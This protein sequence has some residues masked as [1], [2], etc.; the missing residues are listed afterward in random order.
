[1][2]I[3]KFV[4]P[5]LSQFLI[6]SALS[7]QAAQLVWDTNTSSNGAQDGAGIWDT[8]STNWIATNGA[9][10]AWNNANP[11]SA[12]FG[13]GAVGGVVTLSEPITI[14]NLTFANSGYT[15]SGGPLTLAGQQTITMNAIATIDATITGGGFTKA[16]ASTLTLGGANTFTGNVTVSSGTLVITNG[17]SL[18]SSPLVTVGNGQRL[19]LSGGVTVTNTSTVVSINNQGTGDSLGALNSV[20]GSNSWAGPVVLTA[21]QTRIGADTGSTFVLT[22][23]ISSSG[24]NLYGAAFRNFDAASSLTILSGASTYS[25]NTYIV[26]GKVVLDGG[27]NRL[28]VIS[29]LVLGN[30]GGNGSPAILDLNGFNQ[31]LTGLSDL[32]SGAKM[33]TNSS[34]TPVTLTISSSKNFSA[35]N[36]TVIAGNLT[37]VNSGTGTQI[38]A[39]AASTFSGGTTINGGTLAIGTDGGGTENGNGL[40]IGLVTVNSGGQLRFG[41]S[42]AGTSYNITNNVQLAGG[43]IWSQDGQQ[44]LTNATFTVGAAGGSLITVSSNRYLYIDDALTGSGPLTV[45]NALT[46]TN[47]MGAVRF[48]GASNSYSGTITVNPASAGYLGGRVSIDANS[49]LANATLVMQ[50]TNDLGFGTSAT[51]PVLGALAGSGTITLPGTVT[52]AAGNNASNTTYSGVLTGGGTFTKIGASTLTLSGNNTMTN[53]VTI[54]GG[55][56][57]L[58]SSGSLSNALVS[59]G[60]AGTFDVTA[61]SPFI[62]PAGEPLLGNGTVSGTVVVADS[63]RLLPGG[64]G[65]P[66]TLT[67]AGSLAMN[68]NA[69]NTFDL[70]TNGVAGGGVNDLLIINGGLEPSGSVVRINALAALGNGTYPLITYTG[71]KTTSFNPTP[72]GNLTHKTWTIDEATSGQVNFVI[73]GTYGNLRWNPVSS[74]NWN[75]ADTNWFDVVTLQTNNFL[76]FDSVL[77]DDSGAFSPVVNLAATVQP[78]SFVVNSASNYTITGSGKITGATG[79]TKTGPGTLTLGGTDNDYSGL[80]TISNG[81]LKLV[82]ASSL[83]SR[84]AGTIINGGTLD[85]NGTT[86]NGSDIITI[87]GNGFAN[88]GTII[89]SGA[90]ADRALRAMVLGSDASIG[91]Y[92]NAWYFRG[93]NVVDLAGFTLTKLG[94]GQ[95]FFVEMTLTNVGTINVASGIM[96]IAR[97]VT[98][99]PG[100]IGVASN[101]MLSLENYSAGYF[102]KDVALTSGTFRALGNSLTTSS[103]VSVAGSSIIDV[104]AGIGFGLINPVTGSGS[105]TKTENG[106][107]VFKN[108]NSYPGATTIASGGGSI[109]LNAATGQTIF[110]PVQL[111]TVS[112]GGGPTIL[113]CSNNN[114]FAAGVSIGFGGSPVD[115]AQLKLCG[116]SQSV[117]S[118]VSDDNAGGMIDNAAT[119]NGVNSDGLLVIA[120]SGNSI[121]SGSNMRDSVSP[122]TS[123]GKLR[124]FQNG[125]GTLTLAGAGTNMTFAGGVT[126]NNGT[127]NLKAL[128]AAGLGTVTMAG[129][130]LALD[131]AGMQEG[132]IK[133]NVID[134]ISPNPLN[135]GVK[136]SD[137]RANMNA[138]LTNNTE[139][140]YSGYLVVTNPA[141]VTYTFAE[142]FDDNVNLRL[143]GTAVLNDLTGYNIPTIGTVALSPGMHRFDLR[144]FNGASGGGPVNTQWWT[145]TTIGVGFDPLG[146]GQTNMANYQAIADAGDGKLL[147]TDV[148]ISNNISLLAN[149]Q[150]KVSNAIGPTNT[151]AGAITDGGANLSVTKIGSGI[152]RFAG[153]NTYGGETTVSNGTLL[154]DGYNFGTGA[155]EVQT[156]A[157]LWGTGFVY[158]AA[159]TVDGGG[160]IGPRIGTASGGT[161]TVTNLT[162]N[163]GAVFSALLNGSTPTIH[164]MGDV[165]TAPGITLRLQPLA[166]MAVGTH[167]LLDYD[168]A[169]NGSA[170]DF[171]VASF[172]NGAQGYVTNNLVNTSIDLVITNAGAGLKWDGG[173]NGTWDVAGAVNWKSILSGTTQTFSPGD[174]VVFDDTAS[175]NFAINLL[176]SITVTSLSI[177]NETQNYSFSGGGIGGSIGITKYGAAKLSLL[178]ANTFTGATVVAAGTLAINSDSS[179]GTAPSAATP[180]QLTLN[181]G[182]TLEALTNVVVNANRRLAIGPSSGSG[183]ATLSIATGSTVTAS[184]IIANTPG[185]TGAFVK[186]GSGTLNL[187]LVNTYSGG[188]IFDGGT[189]QITTTTGGSSPIPGGTPLTVQN[190]ATLRLANNNGTCLGQNTTMP[191]VVT[192]S[193]ARVTT[194]GGTHQDLPTMV[195]NGGYLS[196]EAPGDQFGN[197]I[198]DK[199]NFITLASASTS[200]ID[201]VS[202]DLR[203][204][205][206]GGAIPINFNVADGAA[207]IDLLVSAQVMDLPG[208]TP[209][210]L[211]KVG[212]G[213]MALVT[214]PSTNI[215]SG[216]TL[217]NNGTFML[218]TNSVAAPPGRG[219]ITNNARLVFSLS[220]GV[221]SNFIAG[222]GVV[223]NAGTGTVTLTAN[224]TYSGGTQISNGTLV[225]NGA[226]LGSG[227][228][229]LSAGAS[230]NVTGTISGSVTSDGSVSPGPTSPTLL[231]VSQNYTQ[232][233]NGALNIKIGGTTGPG[234]D[235]D[236]L[237]VGSAAT[238][239][240]RL[241]VSVINGYSG[242]IGDSFVI[243]S[244]GSALTN[245]FASTNLASLGGGNVWSMTYDGAFVVLSVTSAPAASGYDAWAAGITN[246]KTAYNQFGTSDGYPNL[247]KYATGSSP[248]NSDALARMTSTQ[249]NGLF[250]LKFNHSTT[251]TDITIYVEGSYNIT[252]EA[253]SGI[254]TNLNGSWGAASNVSEDTNS[255]PAVDVVW[256]TD[257]TATN[258]FLRMRVTKP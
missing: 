126:V 44:H 125:S 194:V 90:S 27:G 163:S 91:S 39:K 153:G 51:A 107:L 249:T 226:A 69:T 16:N 247:L 102:D 179:L 229:T 3:R 255:V 182:T 202:I 220:A 104:A 119:D 48:T 171:T 223:V 10:V 245:G 68:A 141:G 234:V 134:L 111:G 218:G 63:A 30:G 52:L 117:D 122:S 7:L 152:L 1:M 2:N 100:V 241:N 71:S 258:R 116:T 187:P 35:T 254:A 38:L 139:W 120:G 133:T 21:D 25:G 15:I 222:T 29:A 209:G 137:K 77:F 233:A 36:G 57:A 236:K 129:G 19:R 250:A 115:W 67:I 86:N 212:A 208:G 34:P 8:V 65:T 231:T 201:A 76:N 128:N 157:S 148:T 221:I 232:T 50:S 240:G 83:G 40:G 160:T 169:F 12:T 43:T 54:S 246:G 95:M 197:Y 161:L 193:V 214:A 144:V 22:G 205:Y 174:A 123:T 33:I 5:V 92:G 59:V 195:L 227:A 188:T 121:F 41:G 243:L 224:N 230:L 94:G 238:L 164:A 170:G 37:L 150:I 61:F 26:L 183:S 253:W 96:S 257:A 9:N 130:V 158:M 186:V 203:G 53:F 190:G 49:A 199:T 105:L 13:S 207:D 176:Q 78:G 168:A 135:S 145:N 191:S 252:N 127:L 228:V 66:G 93:T 181:A 156:N 118:I 211:V 204:Q 177:S 210:R 75:L 155:V 112:D 140:I 4:L 47:G 175:G 149:T 6:G 31:Q 79:V 97:G 151:I 114:Q 14:S 165:T 138:D 206:T 172:P 225:V 80:V 235:F 256:D 108:T 189:V 56:L 146:R 132:V 166:P 244:A 60:A 142:N 73:S 42:T 58:A 11:D 167:V 162:L 178:N 159:T 213:T 216:Y 23:P 89:N 200:V 215:Y 184:S 20:L 82:N 242:T 113:V 103:R 18:G 106:I 87:F 136:L 28:P 72:P 251:A 237:A 98:T 70:A 62:V 143:D 154:I 85:V 173:V 217:I 46:I 147:C 45:D 131:G 239:G 124:L 24:T 180:G 101:A 74:T 109:V 192:V 110:G 99:G 88:T 196:A 185:G 17:N 32:S 64:D 84:D 219:P 248:S 55:T 198:I 81:I